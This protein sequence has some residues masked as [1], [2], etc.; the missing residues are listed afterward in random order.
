MERL[1]TA[2]S[3]YY[4]HFMSELLNHNIKRVKYVLTHYGKVKDLIN[5]V[6]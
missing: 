2:E 5:S 1:Y 3:F 4:S 6:V